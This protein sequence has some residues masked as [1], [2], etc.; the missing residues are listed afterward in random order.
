MV[1]CLRPDSGSQSELLLAVPPNQLLWLLFFLTSQMG[2]RGEVWPSVPVTTSPLGLQCDK[3]LAPAVELFL[4]RNSECGAWVKA[5]ES[6]D[7]GSNPAYL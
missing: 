2:E 1:V 4:I 6:R 5:L 7:L 3:V